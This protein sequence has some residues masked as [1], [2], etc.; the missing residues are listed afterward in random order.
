MTEQAAPTAL[1]RRAQVRATDD[2]ATDRHVY[3]STTWRAGI[4]IYLV[5]VVSGLNR[6]TATPT[7]YPTPE[8]ARKAANRLY[9]KETN[10]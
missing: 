3:I 8:A 2:P 7:E 10:R 5:G 1:N 9:Q 6:N 4:P